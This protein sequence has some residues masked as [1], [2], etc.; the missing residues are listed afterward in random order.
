MLTCVFACTAS[1]TLP[2]TRPLQARWYRTLKLTEAFERWSE[3]LEQAD[4]TTSVARL[5]KGGYWSVARSL[6]QDTPLPMQ[7]LVASAGVGVRG[8]H[9]RIPAYAATFNSPHRDTVPGGEY[10]SGQ[11]W[12]WRHTGGRE[13]LR[14]LADNEDARVAV[15]LPGQY[16]RVAMPDLLFL[17][18]NLGPRAITVFTTDEHAINELGASAVPLAGR[19]SRVLGGTAGQ[20]TVRAL[21]HVVRAARYPQD[22]TPGRAHTLL[23]DILR[24]SPAAL[25]PKRKKQT[26]HDVR[27]WLAEALASGDP[28]TSATNALRR[29]RSDGRGFEQK[30]FSRI[31][32]EMQGGTR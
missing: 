25:Y 2:V 27:A 18:E 12:W 15:A 9:E 26:V 7:A 23:D 32:R 19:M 28:P 16:L 8:F 10:R 29:F 21:D 3:A 11:V 22:V 14:R 20:L 30:H 5:Y 6:V 4:L 24:K 1:K 31:F 13:R 17:Q